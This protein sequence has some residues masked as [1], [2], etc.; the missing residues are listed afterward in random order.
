MALLM[1][2]FLHNIVMHSLRLVKIVIKFQMIYR[3][4]TA[5]WMDTDHP[6]SSSRSWGR[7][8]TGQWSAPI[9]TSSA[10]GFVKKWED[11]STTGCTPLR[12]SS[13]TPTTCSLE[14]TFTAWRHLAPIGSVFYKFHN[15]FPFVYSSLLHISFP[16]VTNTFLFLSFFGGRWIYQ[17]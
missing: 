4:S 10:M 1:P 13:A 14:S 8:T 3:I 6:A 15:V 11:P 17:K 2:M 12:I 5:S 9:T 7:W 16:F